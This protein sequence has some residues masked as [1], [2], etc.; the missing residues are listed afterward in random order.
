MYSTHCVLELSQG[1]TR[2]L[3]AAEAAFAQRGRDVLN[4]GGVVSQWFVHRQQAPVAD[5]LV[6][7]Q[8]VPKLLRQ[9]LTTAQA[10]YVRIPRMDGTD[11]DPNEYVALSMVE[12]RSA[13]RNFESAAP[14]QLATWFEPGVDKKILALGHPGTGKSTFCRHL[15][16]DYDRYWP[17]RFEAILVFNFRDLESQYRADDTLETMLN[18]LCFPDYPASAFDCRQLL[19]ALRQGRVLLVMDGA[20]EFSDTPPP[21]L[22]GILAT[23]F[24]MPC[25][26]ITS[27][28]YGLNSTL[29]TYQADVRC[30]LDGF[31][32]P[33]CQEFIDKFAVK[34]SNATQRLQV[35]RDAVA[36]MP[37][38]AQ[39]MQSPLLAELMAMVVVEHT[40]DLTTITQSQL[41]SLIMADLL[42]LFLRTTAPQERLPESSLAIYRYISARSV[43]HVLEQLATRSF[44]SGEANLS[45]ASMHIVAERLDVSLQGMQQQLKFPIIKA[46]VRSEALITSCYFGHLSFRDFLVALWFARQIEHGREEV[47][48]D[49]IDQHRSKPAAN[50]VWPLVCGLLAR[51]DSD[52]TLRLTRLQAFFQVLLNASSA[53]DQ[54]RQ[55]PMV[56]RC[57]EELRAADISINDIPN[58]SH[59]TDE[60]ITQLVRQ[61]IEN[62][63]AI[64]TLPES[65]LAALAQSPKVLS[66]SQ[67]IDDLNR[68]INTENTSQAIK[69]KAV[70]ALV[71]LGCP[72]NGDAETLTKMSTV[73]QTMLLGDAPLAAQHLALRTTL[74][75]AHKFPH[76]GGIKE[77]LID[78]VKQLFQ[79]RLQAEMLSSSQVQHY[80]KTALQELMQ[81]RCNISRLQQACCLLVYVNSVQRGQY[82]Q[83]L[84]PKLTE[85]ENDFQNLIFQVLYGYREH[86]TEPTT[87][88]T[89]RLTREENKTPV[90]RF[91]EAARQMSSTAPQVVQLLCLKGAVADLQLDDKVLKQLSVPNLLVLCQYDAAR[92]AALP[93]HTLQSLIHR[94]ESDVDDATITAMQTFVTGLPLATLVACWQATRLAR[95]QEVLLQEILD[96]TYVH[97]ASIEFNQSKQ[98]LYVWPTVGEQLPFCLKLGA[99]TGYFAD[100]FEHY[101]FVQAQAS[102]SIVAPR[103]IGL[104]ARASR[105][106]PSPN[107]AT[108]RQEKGCSVM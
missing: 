46:A 41:Y 28:F 105:V 47:M 49:F 42:K 34:H 80:A 70:C 52:M 10:T 84:L 54:F 71:Q 93:V 15:V 104:W 55:V 33:Q 7:G 103:S 40:I 2:R 35:L 101:R 27:R 44:E 31:S 25:H 102:S 106:Q 61:V 85:A 63:E 20:D 32:V 76:D 45:E 86:I 24:K 74:V 97:G 14:A 16:A 56:I 107:V 60:F 89:M 67:V 23:L 66:N 62:S 88:W 6:S 96:H 99:L 53:H 83:Y 82:V 29:K 3:T 58:L 21:E 4:E 26:V 68:L 79:V 37:W 100:H 87:A 98:L 72:Q 75:L 59:Y 22:Q 73:L 50:I 64:Q 11:V 95:L 91:K 38:L 36:A 92:V 18:R 108:E 39:M 69:H 94:L 8:I 90:V 43:L 30:R 5:L 65:L 19:L 48:T 1:V 57:L 78:S 13:Q 9:A 81:Q 17:G 51:S 12:A 77:L